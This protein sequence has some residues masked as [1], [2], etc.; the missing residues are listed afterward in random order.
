MLPRLSIELEDEL[1][2]LSFR[3]IAAVAW[4]VFWLSWCVSPN[5]VEVGLSVLEFIPWPS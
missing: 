3:Y 5:V 1:N 2:S 4:V